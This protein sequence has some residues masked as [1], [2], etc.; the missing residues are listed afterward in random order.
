MKSSFAYVW[1]SGILNQP[2][3]IRNFWGQAQWLLPVT[4]AMCEVEIRRIMVQSQPRQKVSE[5]GGLSL[6]PG[7]N[8]RSYLE[9][10]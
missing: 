7:K 10:N 5:H 9:N 4:S 8:K 3:D 2:N 1:V 6:A